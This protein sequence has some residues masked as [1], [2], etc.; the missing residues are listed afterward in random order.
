MDPQQRAICWNAWAGT[1]AISLNAKR[2]GKKSKLKR[3]KGDSSEYM[4]E[5]FEKIKAKALRRA[6]RWQRRIERQ[7]TGRA[8]GGG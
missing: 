5:R 3:P 6:R 7:V 8:T 1:L 4:R 2:P